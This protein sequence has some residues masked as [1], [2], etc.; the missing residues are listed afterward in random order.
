MTLQEI[1][2]I[3][4]R[5]GVKHYCHFTLPGGDLAS[6]MRV[7]AEC[8]I[9]LGLMSIE[10]IISGKVD[11]TSQEEICRQWEGYSKSPRVDEHL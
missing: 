8:R 4:E 10:D 5:H 6:A 9:S 11:P 3:L 7:C 2:D 1:H